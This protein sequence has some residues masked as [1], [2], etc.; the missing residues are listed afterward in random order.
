[1]WDK[2]TPAY[3][4]FLK[5]IGY[6]NRSPAPFIC[7]SQ[8]T[9]IPEFSQYVYAQWKLAPPRVILS[10]TGGAQAFQMRPRLE[11]MFSQGL[12]DAAKSTDAWIITGG[13][14]TGV[15]E[16][17]GKAVRMQ[18]AK[19]PTIG[20]APLGRVTHSDTF[21]NNYG[22]P[23]P[24]KKQKENGPQSAAL[25]PNHTHFVFVEDEKRDWGGEIPFRSA[26]EREFAKNVPIVLIVVQGGPGTL[27]TVELAVNFRFP[28]ILVEG[29]G[30]AA[31]AIGTY[32]N[33]D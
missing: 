24:Y 11:S 21:T 19:I 20:I 17:V 12:G 31:D 10:V 22:N 13:T 27:K 8:Q 1:M 6:N 32:Y 30:G 15:M 5:F 7:V 28:V 23:L 2:K 18:D 3:Y 25:E 26:L 4:G 9:P 16:F 14:D 33:L 29:S